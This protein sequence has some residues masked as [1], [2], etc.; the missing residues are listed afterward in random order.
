MLRGRTTELPWEVEGAP[1]VV[2]G[3]PPVVPEAP[4]S[5]HGVSSGARALA[6]VA[7]GAPAGGFGCSAV[8]PRGFRAFPRQSQSA[9]IERVSLRW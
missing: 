4:V 2:P 1:G 3:R 6:G 9:A 5:H 8:R 7:N